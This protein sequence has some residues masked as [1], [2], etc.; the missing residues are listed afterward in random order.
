MDLKYKKTTNYG[1]ASDEHD[2][3]EKSR[4]KGNIV[5]KCNRCGSMRI[6]VNDS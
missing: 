3:V 4:D 5:Y 6:T 2:F 1:C